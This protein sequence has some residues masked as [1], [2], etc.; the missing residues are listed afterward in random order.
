VKWR[1][2]S[3]IRNLI[4]R[5][6]NQALHSERHS[7]AGY[8]SSHHL[9]RASSPY[10]GGDQHL[11]FQNHET[12]KMPII[13]IERTKSMA[14][15]VHVDLSQLRIKLRLQGSDQK[16][17]HSSFGNWL[18]PASTLSLTTIPEGAA[19]LS[20]GD[21]RWL[22]SSFPGDAHRSRFTCRFHGGVHNAQQKIPGLSAPSAKGFQTL[23]P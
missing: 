6:F 11:T 1:K 4:R 23:I 18:A 12:K 20:E 21:K 2:S 15:E 13:R 14:S 17:C 19:Q 3:W 22:R 7:G 8:E 5:G 10:K 16:I 9:C